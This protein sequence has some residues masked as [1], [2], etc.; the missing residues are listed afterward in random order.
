MGKIWE[1]SFYINIR[2]SNSKAGY[3]VEPSFFV[4]QAISS[5]P[6]LF[7]LQKFFGK[8]PSGG[9]L[10]ARPEGGPL[11]EILE[12]MTLRRNTYGTKSRVIAQLEM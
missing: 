4:K 3:R 7:A 10:R 9:T 8:P 1:G 12:G 11:G 2:E 6:A 5:A